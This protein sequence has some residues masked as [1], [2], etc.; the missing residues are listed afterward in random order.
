MDRRGPAIPLDQI[1]PSLRRP[2]PRRLQRSP[3]PI[4]SPDQLVDK[5][6]APVTD[7]GAGALD[8]LLFRSARPRSYEITSRPDAS[9]RC[10][11]RHI[12]L[13][14]SHTAMSSVRLRNSDST[15]AGIT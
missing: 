13:L 7:V 11:I 6:D 9:P 8:E 4:E 1:A 14:R 5:V 2:E 3:L 15:L 12:R 10:R